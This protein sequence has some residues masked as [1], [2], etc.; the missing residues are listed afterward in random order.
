[1]TTQRESEIQRA[2][3]EALPKH[4]T[5]L[6]VIRIQCGNVGVKGGRMQLAESGTPDLCVTLKRGR[7]LWIETK[8]QDG[9]PNP[10]QVAWHELHAAHKHR[11]L[12]AR[13]VMTV[14]KVVSEWRTNG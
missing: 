1:M 8:K 5:V 14:W 2:I 9:E 11:I 4:P 3:V 10:A 13:D 6:A 12:V 7:V